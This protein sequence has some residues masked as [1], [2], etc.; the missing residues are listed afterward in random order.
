MS[1][2][3]QQRTGERAEREG[4]AARR[5]SLSAANRSWRS[6]T[7]GA[8]RSTPMPPF[9]GNDTMASGGTRGSSSA[10]AAPLAGSGAGAAAPP[11]DA[12]MGS[13][14]GGRSPK[15]QCNVSPLLCGCFPFP[16][17]R[18]DNVAF[19]GVLSAAAAASPRPP[20]H[21]SA[22]RQPPL[23]PPLLL[24]AHLLLILYESFGAPRALQA[25]LSLSMGAA[26]AALPPRRS[27]QLHPRRVAGAL[28]EA[29]GAVA[30]AEAAAAVIV[31]TAE[32]EKEGD[33]DGGGA[34]LLSGNA[35]GLRP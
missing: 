16:H 27:Q 18:R 12:S 22:G 32:L 13:A 14:H 20:S 7:A 23:P 8:A 5:R 10:S 24:L 11:L 6:A 3:P 28:A 29:A 33:G 4:G 25:G 30:A 17:R 19:W 15:H 34:K 31:A 9:V 1:A 2:P 26:Q 35:Q 21:A